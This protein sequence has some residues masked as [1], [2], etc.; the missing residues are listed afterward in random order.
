[1]DAVAACNHQ[2]LLLSRDGSMY[3]WGDEEA[4]TS[5]ALGLGPSVRDAE[6]AVLTSQRL[7]ASLES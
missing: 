5:G 4:A 3:S 2:T 7:P 6:R 1:V